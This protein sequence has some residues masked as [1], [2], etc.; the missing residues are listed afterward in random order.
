MKESILFL[1]HVGPGK[2][3]RLSGLMKSNFYLLSYFTSPYKDVKSQNKSLRVT[4]ELSIVLIHFSSDFK[5][6]ELSEDG[7]EMPEFI[8]KPLTIQAL[9]CSIVVDIWYA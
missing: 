2:E 4:H 5:M 7:V 8:C 9:H 3:L 1:Y 6:T